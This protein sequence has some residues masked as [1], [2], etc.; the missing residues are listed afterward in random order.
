MVMGI[1]RVMKSEIR[2]NEDKRRKKTKN[3]KAR[4]HVGQ[5]SQKRILSV[6]LSYG[7]SR[8]TETSKKKVEK[9]PL[10]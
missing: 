9:K 6:Q 3:Q 5:I 1:M 2:D 7:R 10:K 8:Q 4:Q